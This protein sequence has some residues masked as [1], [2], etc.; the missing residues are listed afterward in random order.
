[1]L[2]LK[3]VFIRSGNLNK[4]NDLTAGFYHLL[5]ENKSVVTNNK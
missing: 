4:F 3:A 5:T 1:M 2:N